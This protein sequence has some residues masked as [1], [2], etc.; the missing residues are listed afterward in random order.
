[1]EVGPG[2]R[3]QLRQLA[4]SD[5]IL[6][7]RPEAVVTYRLFDRE[8]AQAA[9]ANECGGDERQGRD[10]PRGDTTLDDC[11]HD[12]P[13]DTGS[14]ASRQGLAA[15]SKGL[16]L[17]PGA[18]SIL[19][20]VRSG[21]LIGEV[22]ARSGMSRKALRLYEARGL[23]PPSRRTQ[24]GYRVYPDDVLMVLAFI[25]RARQLGFTL[26]EIGEIVALR[27]AGRAPCTH[28]RALLHK[29]IR[30]LEAL[31]DDLRGT[32]R[33]WGTASGRLPAICPHIES[34]GGDQRWRDSPS[35]PAARTVR[36]S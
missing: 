23:L 29:K 22:A 32:L 14:L 15:T 33:S 16:T 24:S 7:G 30:S 5:L 2:R 9:Q 10:R 21:L 11:P 25:S 34:K 20:P 28:V 17:P 26:A 31:L 3:R 35:A 19:G 12:R 18:R 4:A 1:M 8:T 13:Q 6:A 27:R 36:R